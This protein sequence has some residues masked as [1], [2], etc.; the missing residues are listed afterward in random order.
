M[1]LGLIEL[2]NPADENAT[3]RHAFNHLQTYKKRHSRSLHL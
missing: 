2:K 3:I 1:P